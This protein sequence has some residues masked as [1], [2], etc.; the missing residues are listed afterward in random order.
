LV[1]LLGYAASYIQ[2]A[3]YMSLRVLLWAIYSFCQGCAFTGLWVLAHECGHGAF[4]PSK[5]VCDSVG[6]VIHSS[7]LVPYFSWKFSHAQHHKKTGHL[8][9]DTVFVPAT[10]SERAKKLKNYT[11]DHGNKHESSSSF[12]QLME[13]TPF[14]TAFELVAQQLFGWPAYLIANVTGPKYTAPR[15]KRNHFYPNAPFFDLKQHNAII[16]SDIGLV[17]A[18]VVLT[19]AVKFF[20]SS[21]II[22]YY[23][24]PYLWCNHW[25]VL[26]TYLQHTDPSLPHYRADAWNFARGALA[27]IDRDFGF[28]GK[29]IFHRII[30]THVAHHL[31]SRIPFY[32]A[33]EATRNL[34]RVLKQHYH[35][36]KTNVFVALWRS[37]RACQWVPDAGE[38]VFFRNANKVLAGGRK[39]G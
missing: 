13:E 2:Y 5:T 24:V 14:Y 31:C 11:P 9:E 3:T 19:V 1:L 35:C 33:E 30:E 20:G 4:S 16:L 26:I 32:H 12:H 37:C 18:V 39:S 6:W 22:L 27:T 34:K 17:L 8:G 38:I 10:A 28:I 36:D 29:H 7:L 23:G 25:L 15:W 21:A